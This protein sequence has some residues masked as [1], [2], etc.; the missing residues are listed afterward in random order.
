MA[1]MVLPDYE[2]GSIANLMSTIA[3]ARGGEPGPYAP[4]RELPVT[5]L[6]ST[7]TV[8]LLVID[9]LGFNQLRR[10]C[11]GSTLEQHTIGAL[12]SVFPSTTA[13]AVTTLMTGLAAQQHA[14]TGWHMYLR[15]LGAV[16]AV[17][18]CRTRAG[19]IPFA[20]QDVPPAGLFTC[21]PVFDRVATPSSI[22]A[23]DDIVDSAYSLAHGGRAARRGYRTA[24][25]MCDAIVAL[26]RGGVGRRFVY[27]YFPGIDSL[28]HRHGIASRAVAAEFAR[29]DGAFARLLQRLRG[30][31]SCV[32]VTA[33]HG[34]VDV[35]PQGWTDLE[36]HPRI[37]ETLSQPLCG[38][39]RV[40][41]CYVRPGMREQF[42][43]AVSDELGERFELHA[44]ADLVARGYFGSGAANARLADR[45]GDYTL[46]ARGRFALRDRLP[47][48]RRHVQI[49]VHGGL[50]DDEM[51][52]PLIVVRA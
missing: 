4:L 21:V 41:Y 15:E 20:P 51:R 14:L 25:E 34:F 23:P 30:S 7:R 12:T 36:A 44:S 49:G 11:A 37:A 13:S 10:N 27:A 42:E 48:E 45:V 35:E 1:G 3:A 32:I 8:I 39:P 38:E 50:S 6:A 29:L 18:P 24:E 2:G 5:S 33:D 52:V 46:I 40:A 22:V 31:D 19:E 17:L 26:A 28:A 16:V 9:G 47:G 43:S